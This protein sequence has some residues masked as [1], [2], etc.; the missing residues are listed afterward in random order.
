MITNMEAIT[1]VTE[2]IFADYFHV[3]DDEC[4]NIIWTRCDIRMT[5]RLLTWSCF[6]DMVVLFQTILVMKVT[7][8]YTLEGV[9]KPR[10][11]PVERIV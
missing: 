11:A 1:T 2:N 5:N 6:S 9:N 8:E 7:R 10:F 3:R 4:K